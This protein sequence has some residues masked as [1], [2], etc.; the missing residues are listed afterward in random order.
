MQKNCGCCVNNH[1]PHEWQDFG[2]SVYQCDGVAVD[3]FAE[4]HNRYG[5]KRGMWA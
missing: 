1:E 5:V 2:G 3:R 4:A